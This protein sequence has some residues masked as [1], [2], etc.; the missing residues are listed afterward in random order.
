MWSV[1]LRIYYLAR[2]YIYIYIYIILF[3]Y[4]HENGNF[5]TWMDAFGMSPNFQN[6]VVSSYNGRSSPEPSMFN[7]QS[8][9]IEMEIPLD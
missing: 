6:L 4:F 1:H 9:N 8:H 5:F 3:Y 7:S 2:D